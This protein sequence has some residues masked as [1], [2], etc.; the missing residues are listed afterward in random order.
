MKRLV[1]KQDILKLPNDNKWEYA[2]INGVWNARKIG[3]SNWINI[4]TNS[5]VKNSIAINL[6]KTR[7]TEINPVINRGKS[8]T[9]TQNPSKRQAQANDNDDD[10]NETL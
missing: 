5:K 10:F 2:V 8:L 4:E 6:L 7:H 9:K 3:S 1:I